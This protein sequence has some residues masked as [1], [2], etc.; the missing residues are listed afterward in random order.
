MI[1]FLSFLETINRI[2][3][4]VDGVIFAYVFPLNYIAAECFLAT[5]ILANASLFA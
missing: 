1:F 2:H 5:S 4:E 3:N